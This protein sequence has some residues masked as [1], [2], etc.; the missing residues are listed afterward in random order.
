MARDPGRGLEDEV[1]ILTAF[2]GALLKRLGA[3]LLLRRT[4]LDRGAVVLQLFLEAVEPS[5]QF[6]LPLVQR[7][8]GIGQVEGLVQCRPL[9]VEVGGQQL[10]DPADRAVPAVGI[11]EI[12]CQQ[13]ARGPDGASSPQGGR[14]GRRESRLRQR[15]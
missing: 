3:R 5:L 9:P 13:P 15:G 10:L 6:L 8:A 12:G 14:T 2:E 11:E 4:Y 1:L 7:A